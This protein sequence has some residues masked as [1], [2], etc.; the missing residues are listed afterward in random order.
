MGV[1]RNWWLMR[2][3]WARSRS[4]VE[5]TAAE[6]K[7]LSDGATQS[8]TS[9]RDPRLMDLIRQVI[10]LRQSGDVQGSLDLIDRSFAEGISSNY[11]LDNRARALSQLNC[12]REAI[13]IWEALSKCGDLEL[14]EKAKRLSKL[15]YQQQCRSVLQRVVQLSQLGHA[16][17]ALSVLDVARAEGIENDMLLDNRAKALSQLNREED[18]IQI[19]ESLFES[20]DLKLKEKSKRL[21]YQYKCR[22]VLQH[23]VQLSQLGHATEALSVLDVARAEGIE[24]DML[25]DNR[26][27]ALSQLNREEDAIQIWESLFESSDLKLKEKSKRLVY[28][29]KCRSVL[30][31]VVQLSQLGHATEALSV[32]DVARAEGIE[33]DMLLDNRARVLV[34]L[35]RH[36]EAIS[37]WRQLSQSDSKKYNSILISQL[38]GTL[39]LICRSQGWNVQCFDKDVETLDKLEGGVLQE[40]ELL[41]G[42][43]YTKLLIKLVDQALESG[44]KSPWLALAKA[45]A[46]I[47]LEQFVDAKNFLNH[48]KESVQ[49]QHV[50]VIME[51]MLDALSRDVEVELV[52]RALVPL[53]AK[54]DLDAAQNLLV[55]ALLQNHSCVL[56]E[57]KLQ[58]LLVERGEKNP[59]HQVFE[60]FLGEAERI[61]DT[62]SVS[63]Q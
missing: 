30:Q 63:S 22:S 36:I 33:N 20:S 3:P 28:Q 29:Y 48:S 58:E 51:D 15:A 62:A 7:E 61:R 25:L 42:L 19:W 38:V 46:L 14:Q 16:N 56:Y 43:G 13:Q 24:N 23:V 57:E 41:C 49:D 52:V 37:V 6:R 10:A 55:Q 27:K 45:N 34:Q 54:G 17:E 39:Q 53:K 21:V 18:A 59:E 47:E 31:H 11:L 26:A 32:L 8:S 1:R 5:C 12:E 50:L 60:L 9:D 35:N 40:C 4:S 2:F 44:F